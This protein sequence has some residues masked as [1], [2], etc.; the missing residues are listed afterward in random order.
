MPGVNHQRD[1]SARAAIPARLLPDPHPCAPLWLTRPGARYVTAQNRTF[2]ERSTAH[3]ALLPPMSRR[4][5]ART[6]RLPRRP[7]QS[8]S[9]MA[10]TEATSGRH[11]PL[12]DGVLHAYGLGCLHDPERRPEQPVTK[13]RRRCSAIRAL[14]N[15]PLTAGRTLGNPSHPPGPAAAGHL[16]DTATQKPRSAS[17]PRSSPSVPSCTPGGREGIQTVIGMGRMPSVDSAAIIGTAGVVAGALIGSTTTLLGQRSASRRAARAQAGSLLAQV[18]NAVGAFRM[19]IV[20]FKLRRDS[21]RANGL[22]VGY[23][24]FEVLGGKAEGNWVRGAATSIRE[25]RAWTW[26]RRTGS[27]RVSRSPLARSARRCCCCR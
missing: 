14:I 6:H 5:S 22:A 16:T 24:F 1:R 26:A 13:E 11:R 9:V 4:R 7:S 15:T 10:A 25:L 20:T 12:A 18:R 2:C 21:R 3:Q 19:E 27:R 8:R 17:L 23:A